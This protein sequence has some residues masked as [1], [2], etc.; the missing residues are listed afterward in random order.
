MWLT[1]F[2]VI[3]GDFHIVYMFPMVCVI[4]TG[5]RFSRD[6]FLSWLLQTSH[7]LSL[8]PLLCFLLSSQ[9][10]RMI[11][12]SVKND[13]ICLLFRILRR[14]AV[15]FRWKMLMG[16]GAPLVSPTSAALIL[17]CFFILDY[18]TSLGRGWE[19]LS[20]KVEKKTNRAFCSLCT[21]AEQQITQKS[22]WLR[23]KIVI[24]VGYFSFCLLPFLLHLGFLNWVAFS[25]RGIFILGLKRGRSADLW[26]PQPRSLTWKRR[27]WGRICKSY[28]SMYG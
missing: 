14:I 8:P 27:I 26:S 11:N 16:K 17:C 15:I 20:W 18:P 5:L 1:S 9:N 23:T 7:V 22:E 25:F 3:T 4:L 19:A 21:K 10:L 6:P 24:V 28:S 2:I 12:R 13:L